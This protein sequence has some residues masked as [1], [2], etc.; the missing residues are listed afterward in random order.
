MV[1]AENWSRKNASDGLNSPRYRCILIQRE[2]C[3][4][5]IVILHIQE[6]LC[7]KLWLADNGRLRLAPWRGVAAMNKIKNEFGG[8]HF[9]ADV[10]LW[11]VRWYLQFPISYR[12]LERMGPIEAFPWIIRP[13]RAGR[14][15]TRLRSRSGCARIFK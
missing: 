15:A 14:S 9:T 11:A 12:D 5:A 10:I 4:S 8:R 7:C 6:G 1:S 3:P 13:C 2:M